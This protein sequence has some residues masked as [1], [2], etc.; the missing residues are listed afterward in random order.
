MG[1]RV[2]TT[3]HPATT[4]KQ[5]CKS[6][7]PSPTGEGRQTIFVALCEIMRSGA[8]R[9]VSH[10]PKA[11]NGQPT[12]AQRGGKTDWYCTIEMRN[13]LPLQW[14][15]SRN[16]RTCSLV[17]AGE[18]LWILERTQPLTQLPLGN[19]LPSVRNPLPLERGGKLSSWLCVRL[20][21]RALCDLFH[22]KPQRHK[23]MKKRSEL[24]GAVCQ[25][26]YIFW[27]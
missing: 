23:G 27:D 10:V 13:H 7:Q 26:R 9:F 22:T 19:A 8:V 1:Y 14:E 20:C 15:R 12:K 16:L 2:Y 21:S 5:A 25:K 24:I 11:A 17:A 18:G 4:N 6:S 3:S